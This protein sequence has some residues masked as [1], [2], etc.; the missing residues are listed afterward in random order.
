[1]DLETLKEI[2][3]HQYVDDRPGLDISTYLI[4]QLPAVIVT[5]ERAEQL[6]KVSK[7]LRDAVG[8]HVEGKLTTAELHAIWREFKSV[9]NAAGVV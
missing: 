9:V 2:A 6:Y 3:D 4:G 8:P 1:M 7:R 5:L